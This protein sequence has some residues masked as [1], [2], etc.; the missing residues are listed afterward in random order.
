MQRIAV[1]LLLAGVLLVAS[2]VV[3]GDPPQRRTAPA[4][5]PLPV[6][7]VSQ[8]LSDVNTQVELLRERLAME[9]RFAP[10]SRDPFRFSASV[11]PPP[12]EIAPVELQPV[13]PEPP[14]VPQLVAI[15]TDKTEAG[16]ARRAVF[17]VNGAVQIVKIGD[18]VDRF[19]VSRIDA[20]G[21][22]LT[23]RDSTV[24]RVSIK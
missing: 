21:V 8:I 24:T 19:D 20:D 22:D 6:D 1:V 16:V 23:A 7:Q 13:V 17:A 15:L 9:R 14:P 4:E 10:P 2:W 11:E 3:A 18:R 5:E 12:V